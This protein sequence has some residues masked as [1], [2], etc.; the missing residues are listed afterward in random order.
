MGLKSNITDIDIDQ[1]DKFI[2]ELIEYLP[3]L[4]ERIENE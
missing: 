2:S 1:E 3:I 4:K